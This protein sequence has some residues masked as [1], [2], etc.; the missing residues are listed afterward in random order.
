MNRKFRS[1]PPAANASSLH[2]GQR[3][4]RLLRSKANR[5]FL[6]KDGVWTRDL[7]QAWEFKET[8]EW[9]SAALDLKD[10]ELYYSFDENLPS[11]LD[12]TVPLK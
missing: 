10:V 1:E 9:L 7:R 8:D 12:F 4:R 5:A 11:P 6:T 3:M 2:L